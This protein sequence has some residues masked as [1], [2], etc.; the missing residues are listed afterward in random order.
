[1]RSIALRDL[2]YV[3]PRVPLR[4][5]ALPAVIAPTSATNFASKFGR[6]WGWFVALFCL[7]FVPLIR[8]A[9]PCL[10][11]DL[12][13]K[14]GMRDRNGGKAGARM[15]PPLGALPPIAGDVDNTISGYCAQGVSGMVSRA[16]RAR[17]EPE[18]PEHPPPPS[19]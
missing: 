8:F 11:Q 12:R 17:L 10:P 1:M 13:K 4:K 19:V 2:D 16:T 3:N 18:N 15:A 7:S 5:T 9:G 6:E 14:L